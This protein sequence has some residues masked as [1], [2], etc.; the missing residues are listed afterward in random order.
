MS[1]GVYSGG[2]VPGR[3]DDWKYVELKEEA[4]KRSIGAMGDARSKKGYIQALE[5]DDA[6]REREAQPEPDYTQVSESETQLEAKLQERVPRGEQFHIWGDRDAPRNRVNEQLKVKNLP[7]MYTHGWASL[8]IPEDVGRWTG[9]GW[10]RATSDM[11]TDNPNDS[12]KIYLSNYEVHHDGS[13]RHKDCVLMIADRRLVEQRK[14]GYQRGWNAKVE[15]VY[16][17][18]GKGT[19]AGV[20]D[21]GSRFR[22]QAEWRPEE[23]FEGE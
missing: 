1:E 20:S 2:Y 7:A 19:Q 4:R 18:R 16:G 5:R 15:K 6:R 12:T 22:R 14:K 17:E 21:R 9:L 13:V 8:T 3:Y 23:M 10:I 11:V